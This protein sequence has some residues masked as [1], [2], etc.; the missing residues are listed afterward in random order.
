M[1]D[2]PP[3]DPTDRLTVFGQF[4]SD[5]SRLLRDFRSASTIADLKPLL[6][7]E[8]NFIAVYESAEEVWIVNSVYSLNA[9]FFAE[10]AS[11]FFHGD[12]IGAVAAKAPI[13]LS[14]NCEAIADLLALE[15]LVG[16]DTLVKGVRPVPQGTILH[17]DG[18]RLAVETFSFDTTVPASVTG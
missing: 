12:T 11:A 2:L 13:D 17:W 3:D 10:V 14:W 9:Y 6:T 18:A 5:R 4:V 15:H 8:D 16:N 1:P 7:L